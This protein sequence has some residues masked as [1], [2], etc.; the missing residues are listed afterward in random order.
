ML[1]NLLSF[2]IGFILLLLTP[3]LFYNYSAH[4]KSNSYF[5]IIIMFA[6]IL[7]CFHGLEVMGFLEPLKNPTIKNLP[8]MLFI[9]PIYYLFFEN[10]VSKKTTLKKDISLI[11]IALIMFITSSVFNFGRANNNII[12]IFYSTIYLIFISKSILTFFANK[13]N[14]LELKIR[15]TIKNWIL[16]MFTLFVIMYLLV[17][18]YVFNYFFHKVPDSILNTLYNRSSIVWLIIIFYLLINPEVLY[19]DQLLLKKINT[20]KLEEIPIWKSTKNKAT[21]STDVDVEKMVLTNLEFILFNIKNFEKEIFNNYNVFP[22][23]KEW[24]ITLKYPQSHLKYIFKYYTIYS[25]SEYQN[26]LKIKHALQLIKNGYLDNHTIE[27]LSI[28][29]LFTSRST[30][31]K[32]FKKLTG[33]STTDYV[34]N[35][36][37]S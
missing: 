12:F 23:L 32:N 34:L 28:E 25:F 37:D 31:F 26:A 22:S 27:S 13:K 2:C 21:D 30:F 36:T 19:G 8:F 4:K 35:N 1:I 20:P 6:G 11:A 5:F 14:I 10:M 7:R 16:I 24:S 29:C 15:R 33:Y 9:T 18:L 3:I 17:C